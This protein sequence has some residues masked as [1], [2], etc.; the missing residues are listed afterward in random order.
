MDWRFPIW[1]FLLFFFLF[2]IFQIFLS[3]YSFLKSGKFCQVDSDC[4]LY[5]EETKCDISNSR[6]LVA[7]HIVED[8]YLACLLDEWDS[9]ATTAI[10]FALGQMGY[11]SD[12]EF[13]NPA[14]TITQLREY[15]LNGLFFCSFILCVDSL[16]IIFITH[17]LIYRLSVCKRLWLFF[18]SEREIYPSASEHPRTIQL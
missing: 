4:S 7:Y 17:L 11:L 16:I 14:L 10:F 8:G 15:A 1:F 5:G 6:C 13:N 12:E 9:F 3:S 18:S 2:W